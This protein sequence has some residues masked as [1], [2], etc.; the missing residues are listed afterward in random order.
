MIFWVLKYY[1]LAAQQRSTVKLPSFF[2]RFQTK[3]H[4]LTINK[5]EITSENGSIGDVSQIEDNH[6]SYKDEKLGFRYLYR[7]F[8]HALTHKPQNTYLDVFVALFGFSHF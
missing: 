7:F 4:V 2:S 8:T 6:W 1:F 3:E 5:S